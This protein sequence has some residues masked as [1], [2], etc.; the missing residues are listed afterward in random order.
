[1]TRPFGFGVSFDGFTGIGEAVKI[2]Q[3][4]EAIGASSFWIADHLGY[5]DPFV[6]AAAIAMGTREAVVYP[7]AI[8]PYLRHPVPVA[9]AL[10][11]IAEA[12]PGRVGIAVGVGNPMF[13]REAGLEAN[14]PLA[15]I[16]AYVDALRALFGGAAVEQEAP[17]FRLAG[18]RMGFKVGREP[19]ILIT[20]MGP[21]MLELAGRVADGVVL[22][23]G[24][25]ADYVRRS[26][27][28]SVGET[29][30]VGRDPDDLA[31]AGYVVFMAGGDPREARRKVREKLAFVFRNR[32][33]RDNLASSGLPIDQ[34]AIMAA[35]ARRDIAA[36]CALVPD[37]AVDLFTITGDPQTCRRRVRD[38]RDA[39]LD[40]LVLT[41]V[42]TPEDRMHSID[43][44]AS[45]LK[46]H[47]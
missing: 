21:H 39:G 35:I 2:A 45:I 11:S 34:D 32:M 23:A 9:M 16:K 24:L 15:A 43:Q 36:A 33:I 8:S 31:K 26:L 37:D 25:S 42:G 5:R 18:A 29:R 7:T 44:L 17:T 19:A 46:P 6:T 1:M 4:A 38:Y 20:A 40:L 14:K 3:R 12:M 47:Q 10:A 41:L 27:T 28:I 13:L 22:S 30:R